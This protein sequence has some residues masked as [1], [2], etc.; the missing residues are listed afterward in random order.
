LV[1]ILNTFRFSGNN[2]FFLSGGLYFNINIIVFVPFFTF[3]GVSGI[4]IIFFSGVSSFQTF[5][6]QNTSIFEGKIN[7]IAN[8]ILNFNIAL[9]LIEI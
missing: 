1:G 8:S 2:I 7:F 5:R 9:F 3:T 6:T 4:S